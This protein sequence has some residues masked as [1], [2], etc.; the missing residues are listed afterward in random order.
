MMGRFDYWMNASVELR[1]EQVPGSNY[2]NRD[3]KEASSC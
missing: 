2:A 3:V 1:V